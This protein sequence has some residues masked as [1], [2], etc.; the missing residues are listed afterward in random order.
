MAQPVV[1]FEIAGKDPAKTREYY[2][3]LFGWEFQMPEGMDYGLVAA[4]GE[5]SI[6]GGVAG[7][8]PGQ[9]PYVTIYTQ[10]DELKAYMEKAETL[11]GKIVLPPKDDAPRGKSQKKVKAPEGGA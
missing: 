6:G 2:G 1:H 11:G 9:Q 5:G 3:K 7:V 8:Q 10:V 4:A